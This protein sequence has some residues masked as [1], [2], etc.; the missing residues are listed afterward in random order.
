ASADA[1]ITGENTGDQFGYSLAAGDFNND[2]KTD[3]AMGAY[4]YAINTGRAYLFWN[5]G[6]GTDLGT[7]PCT[8]DCLAANADAIITGE[9]T[10]NYFGYSLAAGDFNNDGKTDLA[11]GAYGYTSSTG[12]AYIFYNDDAFPAVAGSADAIITG[13]NTG[14]QFGYS[15]AAGDFNNDGK[16]DLAVGASTYNTS[17]GRA[18][19]LYSQNG[20]MN[21]GLDMPGEKKIGKLGV[22]MSA[23]DF[24]GDGKTDLA[25]S[26]SGTSGVVYIF[27]QSNFPDEAVSADKIITGEAMGSNFGASLAAGDFNG[28]DKTDLAVGAYDYNSNQGRAYLFFQSNFPDSAANADSIITGETS[29]NYFSYSLAAGDFNNDGKTDLAVGAYGYTSSTGRAYLFYQGNFPDSA[30]NADAIIS[31]QATGNNFGYSLAAGDFN[32]DGKTDLAVGARGYTSNTG[33]AYLFWND[34]TGADFGTVACTTGCLAANADAI[35]SGQATTNYFG[36][37]LAAGDF[38]ADGKTDLAVGAYGYTTFTGR[39]YLFW[40]DGTGADFGTAACTTGCLA[41]NADAIITGE[42][43]NNYFGNSLA[44]GDFNNDGK[45]DLAVGAYGY[46]SNQGRTYLFYQGNFPDSAA[47]ADAIISGQATTNY[48]GASLAAGDFNNDGKTDLAVGAYGYTSSTGRAYL[49]YQSNFPDSA[50]SASAIITGEISTINLSQN[51]NFGAS[52]AAGDFNNDGKTDLAVGAYFYAS[53]TGRTY[54]FYQ[55]NFP[56]SAANADAIITGEA[57]TNDF[58]ISLAAGDFNNDGKTDLAVGAYGYNSNQGRTYLF[59]QGNFPDSAANADAIISGQATTN[60]FGASLA[61]GDFNNDGKTDL[62]V[63]AYGYTSNTG[64]AYLFW[65]DGTG[66]DFGTVA[67]TTGCLAANADAIISGQATTNDFGISLAAGDFNNDGKTDLAV[68]ARGYTT[69]TGRAY[70]FWNDGTGADFGTVAC[71][72]GCLAANAD[73]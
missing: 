18:Y 1:I 71:T 35:I 14:D 34:G 28:D 19:I 54:L 10:N 22:A 45:T 25:I 43:T 51:N 21:T 24:N 72:T 59:Y 33:R 5:D 42:T 46:T 52:L 65:N 70:L 40:N 2:G 63:G 41:A 49:F 62:A 66:A 6:T 58:G 11:V 30:A 56:D 8:T 37:S 61:A 64:R 16:T 36:Y 13:E 15:L 69:F 32:N 47:N 67:C 73:P 7:F 57:T 20:T 29:S 31:G 23:G 9:T 44:A 26:G 53:G 3:L 48:F 38:N 39:A 55:S 60:Y 68:G 50:V 17:K 27:Y 4:G 12:R